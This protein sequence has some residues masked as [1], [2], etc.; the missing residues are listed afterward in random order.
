MQEVFF[1]VVYFI[2][3]KLLISLAQHN[4]IKD[5]YA[6]FMKQLCIAYLC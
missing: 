1:L 2:H 3:L 4:Q 6:G 5:D